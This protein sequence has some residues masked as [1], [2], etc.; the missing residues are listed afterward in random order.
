MLIQLEKED[1]VRTLRDLVLAGAHRRYGEHLT[2]VQKERINTELNAI[3]DA[4]QENYFLTV[5]DLVSWLRGL[6]VYIGPGHGP[7]VGSVVCYC[8]NITGVD[9]I[10]YG[11]SFER[12]FYYSP[13]QKTVWMLVDSNFKKDVIDFIVERYGE[14]HVARVA[15]PDS[16]NR[17]GVYPTSVVLCDKNINEVVPAKVVK[18]FDSGKDILAVQCDRLETWSKGLVRIEYIGHY[19]LENIDSTLHAIQHFHGRTIDIEHIPLDDEDTLR[20]F[21]LGNTTGVSQFD[22]PLMKEYLPK[23]EPQCFEELIAMNAMCRMMCHIKKDILDEY[24]NRK[25][26]NRPIGYELPEMSECLKETYGIILYDEQLMKLSQK[27]A[28]I[29]PSVSAQLFRA[30]KNQNEEELCDYEQ[31]FCTGG[32]RNG[33]PIDVLRTVWK[34]WKDIALYTIPKAYVTSYSWM[35]YQTAWLKAHYPEEYMFE[36]IRFWGEDKERVCE[37][38]KDCKKNSIIIN[39]KKMWSL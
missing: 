36:V 4:G 5:W 7:S 23:I 33:Y 37:L 9:P 8:L 12:Y 1:A 14:R 13:G 19:A 17:L 18:D 29:T 22:S 28:G 35:A 3:I 31:L 38:E 25:Q 20:L 2:K 27:I 30:L 39:Y 11:L 32:L 6:G 26:G 15:N 16:T 10:R 21:R 24:F 34:N